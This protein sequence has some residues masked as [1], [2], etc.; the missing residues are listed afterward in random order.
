MNNSLFRV[1]FKGEI[2]PGYDRVPV[3][4]NLKTL[5]NYDDESL[6]KLFSGKACIIKDR[7]EHQQAQKYKSALEQTGIVC[8]IQELE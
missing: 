6:R 5:C 8:H 1:V 4:Q 2:F 3:M 7:I